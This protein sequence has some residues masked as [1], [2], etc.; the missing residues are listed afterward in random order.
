[1]VASPDHSNGRRA[2]PYD[3]RMATAFI[4]VARVS[5]TLAA[6]IRGLVVAPSRRRD[7]GNIAFNLE[8]AESD[9]Y[10]DAM[11][12]LADG[13][14]IGFYRL[15][16]RPELTLGNELAGTDAVL[17]RDLVIDATHAT[18]ANEMRATT[19]ITADIA[20]HHPQMRLV[21]TAVACDSR[22]RMALARRTGFIDTGMF[23]PGWHGTR[24]LLQRYIQRPDEHLLHERRP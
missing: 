4:H 11:A 10:S 9:P 6:G 5:P 22:D 23:L 15:D 17:L 3:A 19:A 1:V 16:F 8:A 7:T 18:T 12:I 14:I 21:F 24:H 20:R 2:H 13:R